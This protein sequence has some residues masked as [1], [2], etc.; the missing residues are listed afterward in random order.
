MV[1]L[2]TPSSR[3]K[4]PEK[5]RSG[6]STSFLAPIV[7]SILFSAVFTFLMI[8][9]IYITPIEFI[10][11]SQGGIAAAAF[12]AVILSSLP[13]IGGLILLMILKKRKKVLLKLFIGVGFLLGGFTIFSLILASAMMISFNWVQGDLAFAIAVP[14]SL[15]LN[16]IF[17]YVV[18]SARVSQKPKNIV[19]LLYGGAIGTLLGTA[20]PLWTGLLMVFGVSIYDV[21]SVR[22]GPLKEIVEVSK[23]EE[24]LIPGLSY[25][26][27]DWEIGLGDLG[28]YSMLISL[29][30]TQ[31]GLVAC[32]SSMI[33]I[34]IG[35]V[36]TLQLLKKRE[37][38]PGLPLTS[39]IGA[40]PIIV[41][42]VLS[43]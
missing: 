42:M 25:V 6:H 1:S 9:A 27:R 30:E 38:L 22:S 14:L 24:E 39:L 19:A 29:A 7:T 32:V 4:S 16:I 41:F 20:L 15:I 31:F 21:Y 10:P 5:R 12:N 28:I 33:G 2:S 3:A 26:S 23:E 17:V 40:I 37:L 13:L 18:L 8:N 11:E 34:F 35:S 36:L 43:L